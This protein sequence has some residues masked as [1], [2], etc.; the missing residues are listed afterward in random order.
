MYH[1]TYD[2]FSTQYNQL[3]YTSEHID[4]TSLLVGRDFLCSPLS[5]NKE[6]ATWTGS[7]GLVSTSPMLNILKKLVVPWKIPKSNLQ[8]MW[9]TI[10]ILPSMV[11]LNTH[12]H[13][14]RYKEYTETEL[15]GELFATSN[16]LF[17]LE[18]FILKS[19]KSVLTT[20]NWWVSSNIIWIMYFFSFSR[21]TKILFKNNSCHNH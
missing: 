10:N 19:H 21:W 2:Q 3:L 5:P 8:W 9:I 1:W 11:C 18:S 13:R 7:I 12:M 17:E 16:L 20:W 15:T 6:R 14:E 4:L